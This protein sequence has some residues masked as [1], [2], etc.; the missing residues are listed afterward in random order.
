MHWCECQLFDIPKW[1]PEVPQLHPT[2]PQ[3]AGKGHPTPVEYLWV[4]PPGGWGLGYSEYWSQIPIPNS[5]K[6]PPLLSF[7]V[8]VQKLGISN[9]VRPSPLEQAIWQ[10]NNGRMFYVLSGGTPDVVYLRRFLWQTL[11]KKIDI[12]KVSQ[13][14]IERDIL[15]QIFSTLSKLIP[16]VIKQVSLPY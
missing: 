10:C 11:E 12:A 8:K 3:K 1:A 14:T 6:C 2:I 15:W 16:Q 7:F 5:P 4:G 13:G 9:Y